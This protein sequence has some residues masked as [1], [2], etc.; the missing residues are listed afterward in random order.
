MNMHI[1]RCTI[2]HM[3]VPVKI[4]SKKWMSTCTSIVHNSF[5]SGCLLYCMNVCTYINPAVCG[6]LLAWRPLFIRVLPVQQGCTQSFRFLGSWQCCVHRLL[7]CS[8]YAKV[9][10][11]Y[12]YTDYVVNV[13]VGFVVAWTLNIFCCLCHVHPVGIAD[14]TITWSLIWMSPM[15][16]GEP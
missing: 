1:T 11:T 9:Q 2:M 7:W 10:Y 3:E 4:K 12:V 15:V 13:I 14:W 16:C 5:H 6:S 8:L